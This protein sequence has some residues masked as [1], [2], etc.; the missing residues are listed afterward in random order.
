MDFQEIPK[1]EK[2]PSAVQ[3]LFSA[4]I[5]FEDA[6]SLHYSEADYIF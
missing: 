4:S 5:K 2:S 3:T 6:L 1:N